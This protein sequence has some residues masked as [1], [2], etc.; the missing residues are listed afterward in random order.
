MPSSKRSTKPV[1]DD[2]CLR[3]DALMG[4]VVT[5]EVTGDG[6]DPQQSVRR[7]EAVERAF[8]WFRQVE[9]I[10]TRFEAKS[11]S[12]QLAAH[13]GV[14]VPVST[15][16]YE[17]VRFA[18]AVAEESGGAF[19]PTVGYVMEKRGFNREHRSGHV[20]KTTLKRGGPVS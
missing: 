20:I 14:P 15:I 12:M 5:I 11:E 9:E 3:S 13:V 10:C 6:A 1:S 16:L 4:T 17:A 7:E 19:D 8:G 18:L 2:V